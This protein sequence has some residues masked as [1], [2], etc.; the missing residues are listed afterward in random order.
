[1][2][3]DERNQESLGRARSGNSL[4]NYPA[5]F[6]GFM[7]RGIAEADIKP[8]ENV[9]TFNAWQALGKSVKKGEHGIRVISWVHGSKKGDDGQEH[10]FSFPKSS[11]VFHISQVH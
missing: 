9:F 11:T 6:A 5:I 3:E 7:A 8:R 4:S 1:M 10:G 2:T